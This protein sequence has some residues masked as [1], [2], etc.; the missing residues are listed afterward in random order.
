MFS[1]CM[2]HDKFFISSLLYFCFHVNI[3]IKWALF[4]NVQ[5]NQCNESVKTIIIGNCMTKL[6]FKI[7]LSLFDLKQL[8]FDSGDIGETFYNSRSTQSLVRLLFIDNLIRRWWSQLISNRSGRDKDGTH[9]IRDKPN[10]HH[11]H[12]RNHSKNYTFEL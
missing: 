6:T 8:L 10:H 4:L 7:G 2:Y 3:S 12:H 1:P 9:S 11:H 5:N